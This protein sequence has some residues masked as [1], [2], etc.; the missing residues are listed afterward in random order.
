MK[1]YHSWLLD[2]TKNYAY[3]ICD[4]VFNNEEISKIITMSNKEEELLAKTDITENLD[5]EAYNSNEIR[6][7][8]ISWIDANSDNEWM[9]RK[10]TDVVLETNK[11]YFNFDL[12]QIEPLQFTNYAEGDFYDFHTDMFAEHAG[13]YIRKLSFSLQ[14][15][16]E[17]S[18]EGGD[19]VFNLGGFPQDIKFRKKGSMIFFPSFLLHK[20]VPVTKGTRQSL[21]GWV[22]GPKF[23]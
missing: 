6:K 3:S 13:K 17:N 10:L 5:P 11:N 21:V 9:F 18:Y 7:G 4:D 8:T 12:V 19:L 23:K 1:Q 16:D 22:Q 15:T 2:Y 14:L 20:V